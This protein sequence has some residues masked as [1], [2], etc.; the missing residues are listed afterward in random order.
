MEQLAVEFKSG[1]SAYCTAALVSD[2][3]ILTNAHCI[4]DASGNNLVR[5][6]VLSMGYLSAGVKEGTDQYEVATSS[7][8]EF[9]TPGPEGAPDYVILRVKSGEPGKTWGTV[10]LSHDT[11][12]DGGSLAIMHHPRG[13]PMVVSAGG[14]CRSTRLS[15]N[16]VFHICDTQ[17]GVQWR[18]GFCLG[19]IRSC[20]D[21][22]PESRAIGKR[23]AAYGSL[24][25][26]ITPA[27]RNSRGLWRWISSFIRT[28]PSPAGHACTLWHRLCV[29]RERVCR[30]HQ[31]RCG[32]PGRCCGL[33]RC[34]EADPASEPADRR[35][36]QRCRGREP[37]D[38]RAGRWRRICSR[39]FPKGF[40]RLQQGRL[41]DR[42]A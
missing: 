27:Q 19:F 33:C 32:D 11:P 13:F 6:G 38:R 40:E 31:G 8:I 21:T 5:A 17:G 14:K 12:L 39:Q 2:N 3:L 29:R 36:G 42:T 20:R 1:K 18:A 25:R 30:R 35:G 4:F 24:A 22:L 37:P 23:C 34:P 41:C 7:P 28:G 9:G 26:C 15:P 10:Q 16:D